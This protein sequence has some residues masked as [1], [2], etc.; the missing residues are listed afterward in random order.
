MAPLLPIYTG[1]IQS[2]VRFQTDTDFGPPDAGGIPAADQTSQNGR[3]AANGP[4]PTLFHKVK[5]QKSILALAVSESK[6]YAGTQGGELLVREPDHLVGT[7]SPTHHPLKV[8]SLE[9]Y[10]LLFSVV[11]HRGSILCL[12]L[13]ADKK[14]LLSSAGDAIVNARDS[15]SSAM[16]KL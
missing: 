4:E 9:T 14:L 7:C 6:L 5:N 10:E 12:F 2:E 15:S 1:D 3:S 13:S 16:R 8:W 11:A